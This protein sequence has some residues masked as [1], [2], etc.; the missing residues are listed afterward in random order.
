MAQ[1]PADSEFGGD[2]GIIST[3]PDH[4]TALDNVADRKAGKEQALIMRRAGRMDG[5]ATV[6]EKWNPDRRGIDIEVVAYS[7]EQ[8]RAELE[9]KH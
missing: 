8:A 6:T 7:E 9:E 5:Y 1:R 3:H 4:R 2:G